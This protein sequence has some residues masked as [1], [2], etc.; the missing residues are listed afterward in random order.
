MATALQGAP[1]KAFPIPQGVVALNVDRETGEP[2]DPESPS[3]VV[4]YFIAGSEPVM[5]A[6]PAPGE[7]DDTTPM[8][9]P[10]VGEIPTGLF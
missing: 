9:P 8:P 10:A 7:S 6:P 5:L 3:A 1:E 2:T 4:E